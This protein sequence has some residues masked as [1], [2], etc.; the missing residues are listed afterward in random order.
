[1]TEC[2]TGLDL[3]ALQIAVA[4]GRALAELVPQPL[5]INGHAVEVRLYAEDPAADWQ[6]QSGRLSAFDVPGVLSELTPLP[7]HG[8]RLDSGVRAGDEIGTHYDAM[9]AKVISWAPTRADAFRRLAGTLDRAR[10]H[11]LRTNRDLLVN[12]LRD[13][14]ILAGEVS[15]D[16]LDQ[17]DL[18][19]LAGKEL[20]VAEAAFAAAVALAEL[21][22]LHRPVQTRVPAGWRNV[23]SQPQLTRFTHAEADVDVSWYGGR[24]GFSSADLDVTVLEA[25]PDRVVLEQGGVAATYDVFVDG[26]RV[27]VE[28]PRGHVAL[29]RKPRFVDPAEQLAEGS[30]LA[31]MPG[32]VVAVRAATGD[33]V[34][35]GQPVLVLE[36]MKMQHTIAAPYDGVVADIKVDV[37]VQ[38]TAGDV[39]AVVEQL[40]STP[41]TSTD[42]SESNS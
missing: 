14:G 11:G 30:L 10:I 39:L 5:P 1:V 12:L 16:L 32:T 34:A 25:R 27:D 33:E 22:R 35:S 38:V 2:V 4:E 23:V 19:T 24:E 8:I 13:P 7:A 6:P 41:T 18:S 42:E 28:S 37:G 26:D 40:G 3:V 31:P 15:T 20:P 9:V 21:A 29:T 17:A 36:A